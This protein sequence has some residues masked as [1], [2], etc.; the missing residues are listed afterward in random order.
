MTSRTWFSFTVYIMVY[1]IMKNIFYL[2]LFYSSTFAFQR[3][4]ILIQMRRQIQN[5]Q[6]HRNGEMKM[7]VSTG[8]QLPAFLDLKWKRISWWHP[9]NFR[10]Q[11][12]KWQDYSM[13][14]TL[15]YI[16]NYEINIIAI[17]SSFFPVHQSMKKYW[18]AFMLSFLK[19]FIWNQ[20]KTWLS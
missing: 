9:V 8:K 19:N 3:L 1:K 10:Y 2:I 4:L 13:Y 18:C 7:Q 12:S 15:F 17:F 16:L 11:K 20:R 5:W 14:L 6:R